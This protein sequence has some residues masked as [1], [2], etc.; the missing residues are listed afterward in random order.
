[1]TRYASDLRTQMARDEAWRVICDYLGSQGFKQVEEHGETVWRK[2]MGLAT[3]PQFVHAVPTDGSVHL[4]AWVSAVSIV[5]G[6]YTG[7]QDLTGAWG[8]A[9][10]SKLKGRVTALEGLLGNDII[11]CGR[12]ESPGKGG[13]QAVAPATP[14][15]DASLTAPAAWSE[16]PA[17]RHQLRYWDGTGWTAH[18]S[19]DGQASEDPI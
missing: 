10:K 14:T 3:I 9:L 16:D 5:P 19:D 1:M 13:P 18:V 15:P 6:V 2:G 4:E 12:I 7:E 17:G 8:F 11:S